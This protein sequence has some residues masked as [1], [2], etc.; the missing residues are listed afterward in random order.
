MSSS[1]TYLRTH[2]LNARTQA[3][4][5]ANKYLA[6]KKERGRGSKPERTEPESEKPLQLI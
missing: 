6:E 1:N 3:R 5:T 4:A 2:D